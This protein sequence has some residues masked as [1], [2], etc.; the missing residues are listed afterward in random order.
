[1]NFRDYVYYSRYFRVVRVVVDVV[2]KFGVKVIV[3]Q[4]GK[5]GRLDFEI[6]VFQSFVDML[7]FFDIKIVFENIFSVK[8]MFY[9]VENVNRDNVGFVFDV[10]YVFLSVQGNEEKFFDDVKFGMDKMI[11]FMVYDNFG[12]F[13]LQVELEDVLVYGVGD[14]YFFFGEGKIFFGKVLKFFGDVLIFLKVK[15]FEKFLKILMKQGFI[16]LFFSF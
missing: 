5:I 13:F 4:S 10:V 9:V 8:D 14:F 7:K 16:D 6:E 1:M 3:M 2:I 11:I 15:D 12:K